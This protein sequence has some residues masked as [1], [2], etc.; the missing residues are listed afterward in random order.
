MR[1]YQDDFKEKKRNNS[2]ANFKMVNR[3]IEKLK[4]EQER[5]L[6]TYFR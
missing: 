1:N 5:I 2:I 4:E 3:K 6:D